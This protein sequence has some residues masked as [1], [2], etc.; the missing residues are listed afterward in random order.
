MAGDSLVDRVAGVTFKESWPTPK[1]LQLGMDLQNKLQRLETNIAQRRREFEGTHRNPKRLRELRD[2]IARDQREVVRL[3]LADALEKAEAELQGLLEAMEE[4][5]RRITKTAL[6]RAEGLIDRMRSLLENVESSD[7]ALVQKPF[8][9]P[10]AFPEVLREG[11]PNAGFDIVLAN[12]PYVRQ[13]RLDAEDQKSYAEAFPEVYA[14]TADI[15]VCFYARALQILRREQTQRPGG[16]LSFITSNK[17]MR[18]AYGAGTREHLPASLRIQ[19]VLDFGDLPLFE[20]NGKAI[21]AYPAVLVGRRSDNVE[22]HALKVA[23][24]SGPVRKALLDDNLRVNP[25]S[26]RGVLEDLDGLLAG[27][28]ISDFPQVMLKRDGWVLE[29]PALIRLFDRLMNQGT[30]LREFVKGRIYMGVKTGFNE[31]FVVDQDKRNELI[32]EDPRS[33]ELIKPWLRGRDI[34]RWKTD[35]A[36]QYFIAI[37]NSGD[38]SASNPWA[39]AGSE[40]TARNIFRESYP[41]IHDHLSWFEPQLRSRQDQGRYWW[42]LRA[43]AYYHE[44]SAQKILINNVLKFPNFGY[45]ESGAFASNAC[46]FMVPPSPSTTA[47]LNSS[48]GSSLLVRQCT[49]LQNGYIQ[50]FVQFLEQLPIPHLSQEND[51]NLS[52]YVETLASGL[53]VLDIESEIDSLVFDAYGLSASERKLV[54]DWLGER[55]EALGAEMPPDWRKLNALRSTAGAWRGNVD[56]DEL[57]RDIYASRLINTRPEPRL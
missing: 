5:T 4:G 24:L 49:L 50:V 14:G 7:F 57:I 6:K 17:F 45:D 39:D 37:Q 47:V 48:I 9:W 28:E 46:F 13:E 36:G 12:P 53:D 41:A 2:L 31:A 18:A 40:E 56:A 20:A 15:L 32:E 35:W 23:D 26:V 30:S 38:S 34:E 29:D 19:R 27:A 33:E 42:E 43:C 10:I 52:K 22:V 8:L 25:E 54:L 3:H 1:D 11:D 16:W 55:R 44:F 21:A 51:Q